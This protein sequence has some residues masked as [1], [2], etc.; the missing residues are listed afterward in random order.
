MN[1]N[2]PP[3]A[4]PNAPQPME[5]PEGALTR[6][7]FWIYQ[8]P[9]IYALE[10]QRIFEGPVWNYLCLEA[11]VAKPGD[12]RVTFVGSMPVIV[13]RDFDDEIYAFENRCAHRGA[14]IALDCGGHARDFTCV[15]HAW[16]YDLKGNLKAVAFEDGVNGKGGMAKTFC[17]SDHGPRKLRIAI[18]C[19]LVFGSLSDDVPPIEEYLG[20]EIASRDQARAAQAGGG[21]RPLHADAAEQLE[22]LFRE[23]QGHLSRVACCTRSSPRSASTGCRRS[24]GMVVSPNGGNHAS[25]SFIDTQDSDNDY[26]AHGHPLRQRGFRAEGPEPARQRRRVRRRLPH[27]DPHGVSELRAAADP[28]CAG[29]PAGPAEGPDRR[30][31]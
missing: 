10:Q 7:P 6:I 20:E 18:F 8:S 2:V 24:G 16:N 4:I 13:A 31:R 22:A 9:E 5:W 12:Y 11:E 19:G 1:V 23:R 17:R 29:D 27:A 30:P 21:D 14:L 25:F 3:G 26:A 28:E 15:Y